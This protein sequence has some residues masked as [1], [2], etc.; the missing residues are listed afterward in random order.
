MPSI[1]RLTTQAESYKHM[2]TSTS[3]AAVSGSLPS[4]SD[5][6]TATMSA[7]DKEGCT[8]RVYKRHMFRGG[9]QT[10][11]TC[12]DPILSFSMSGDPAPESSLQRP[13]VRLAS[14]QPEGY[15]MTENRGPALLT[16]MRPNKGVIY[17]EDYLKAAGEVL[18][19]LFAVVWAVT[20]LWNPGVIE[21]NPLKDRPGVQQPLCRV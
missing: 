1:T 13:Q 15:R 10:D 17:P 5:R 19:G 12:C 3:S 18:F 6:P 7:N 16:V 4:P 2:P 8:L 21:Q 20:Y 11:E 9:Q 14:D